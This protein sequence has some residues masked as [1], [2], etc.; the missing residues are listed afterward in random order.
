VQ[1]GDIDQGE[2]IFN[3]LIEKNIGTYGAMMKGY[4]KHNQAQKAIDLF[5]EIKHPDDIIY[6]LLMKAYAHMAS[7]DQ[8]NSIKRIVE[9]IPKSLH[10]NTYFHTSLINAFAQCGD[11]ETAKTIFDST[12]SKSIE[13]YG[14]LMKGGI[15]SL[16]FLNHFI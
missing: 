5:K 15:I 16:F 6:T 14:A 10:S 12:T 3:S 1:C 8:L 13:S 11:I 9:T 4:I 7:K 2:L